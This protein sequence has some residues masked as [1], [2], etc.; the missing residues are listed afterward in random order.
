MKPPKLALSLF[1]AL[2]LLAGGCSQQSSTDTATT[3]ATKPAQPYE[4]VAAQGKGFT[5]GAVMSANTVYV[6]FDPQCPHCGHLWE[7]SVPLLKKVKFVWIPVAIMGGKSTPQG[8]ALLAAANPAELMA[9]H[10]KSVLAGTGGIAASANI[11]AEL[12]QAIQKN[13]QLFNSLGVDSVPYIL[14]RNTRTGQVV[15]NNGALST[16]ALA[17]FLGLE[18]P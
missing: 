17:E 6:L 16:P 18:Q 4:A 1:A 14:A 13:T 11:P 3:T 8:A 15:T 5:V 2:T 7:A 12:E 10:E 9:E